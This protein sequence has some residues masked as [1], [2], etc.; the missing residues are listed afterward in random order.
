MQTLFR[1]D[2][3]TAFMAGVFALHFKYQNTVQYIGAR[4]FAWIYI[5]GERWNEG[6]LYSF[7]LA[8]SPPLAG[9][10]ITV[11]PYPSRL[12]PARNFNEFPIESFRWSSASHLPESF[13][14]NIF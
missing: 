9:T 5:Y 6:I 4:V 7:L 1:V 3:L 10:L 11:G 8:S 13:P 12:P 2:T 14:Q